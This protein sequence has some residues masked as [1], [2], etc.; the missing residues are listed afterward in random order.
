MLPD[1]PVDHEEDAMSGSIN[2]VLVVDDS[3]LQRRILVAS[4]KKWGFDVLEA[5]GG[6]Q[7]MEICRNDPPDLILSDW[8]MPGMN[9]IEF[10]REFRAQGTDKYSY[11]ILLTSKSEKNEVAEGLDA[12]ADDFLTK[13]VSSDELRARISAGERILRM[14]RELSEKN[15][16]VSE[17][18]G[19]LQR[20]Y[21]AIDKD[22]IQAR[23]IQESL[24]PEL[25]K[26]FG[27]STV[28]LLLKPCGHIG[29]D[30]VGM[31]C[32]GVNRI[33]FYS[34]D[35][36]GHGITSAMMT[37]RL[38]GYLSST[39]FDQNVGMEKRFN[40]FYALR[41]PEEVASMLNAR[42]IADTGIEEYFTM[43]YCIVDLRSGVLKMVQAGHPHPLLLRKDGT[44]EFIGKGG[45]PVGLVPD[46]GYSQEELVMEKGDR[47]LLYSDG[48]TEAR[49]ESGEMLEAEGLLELIRKCDSSQS[50]KEFLD[51]LYWNLTQILSPE[52]GL[53][54][55]VSA[56]LFEYEGP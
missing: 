12:G 9:G 18:L 10:C 16:I 41:Q 13:P 25:S 15:R 23:K 38:G 53:E 48:F 31:F 43:A 45:V 47:L 6:E 17:T 22:L 2:R 14:Q 27:S 50:G 49:L 55:D 51:D 1:S 28:S 44:A 34:I 56:T 29:G 3:R 54:D 36:S 21:D 42:L 30:L 46:I 40:R 26:S 7:A 33:G 35:V 52:H 39:Y 5:E 8:M 11:F 32:P 19:E 4:L 20:V 37:A 24:V